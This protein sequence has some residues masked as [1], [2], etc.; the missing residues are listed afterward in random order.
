MNP[1]EEEINAAMELLRKDGHKNPIFVCYIGHA[2][3]VAGKLSIPLVTKEM[4]NTRPLY[5]LEQ[6]LCDMKDNK[7]NRMI[8]GAFFNC[9]RPRRNPDEYKAQLIDL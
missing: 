3:E 4:R 9:P 5:P 1:N 6:K 8:V 7:G 2:V